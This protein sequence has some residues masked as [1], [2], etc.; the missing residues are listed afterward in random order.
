MAAASRRGF[1]P[2]DEKDFAAAQLAKLKTAAAD[3]LY[4][5]DRGYSLQ[6]A[7]SLVGD[8]YQLTARQRTAVVRT[9]SPQD[10]LASRLAKQ[11]GGA[12]GLPGGEVHVDGFNA[13][14]ALEVALSGSPVF[15]CMDGT[16]RDLAG[17]R[18]TYRIIDKTY[19]AV[20]LLVGGLR[21]LGAAK[22]AVYL[23][24]PVSN[25][26]RLKTLINETARTLSFP[27]E[28][29][30]VGGVDRLLGALP[31]VVTADSAVLDRCISWLNIGTG[32]V[33][34]IPGVWL[35]DIRPDR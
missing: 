15:F 1:F 31:G 13:V 7:A 34:A 24:A 33:K 14:I 28:A 21:E 27:A 5:S 9:V 2:G 10:A 30:T 20:R 32:L 11:L 19:E 26:G 12:S 6:G 35:L 3:F 18:G 25:S 4:L 23:D 16:V 17:L 29:Q 22:A 8:R